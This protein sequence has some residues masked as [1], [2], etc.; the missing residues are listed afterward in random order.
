M[1]HCLICQEDLFLSPH[2]VICRSILFLSII[3]SS[4]RGKFTV[5]IA[6]F[7]ALICVIFVTFTIISFVCIKNWFRFN[8]YAFWAVRVVGTVKYDFQL[9]FHVLVY[10]RHY[11]GS[12]QL[13][14]FMGQISIFL[15][16]CMPVHLLVVPSQNVV[17]DYLVIQIH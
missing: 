6:I 17:F 8:I 13:L 2:I 16:A 1:K 4:T 15:R 3:A 5:S 11:F 9:L 12:Y 14:F 10:E 7:W